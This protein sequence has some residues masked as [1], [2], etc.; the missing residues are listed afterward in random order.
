MGFVLVLPYRYLLGKGDK[1]QRKH[2]SFVDFF[3]L[4]ELAAEHVGLDIIS[5]KEFLETIAMTGQLRDKVDGQVS[6]PPHNRTDW[7][8]IDATDY[9]LLRNWLRNVTHTPLW[10]PGQCLPAFPQSGN[11]RDVELL[12][13]MVTEINEEHQR[14]KHAPLLKF[15]GHPVDVTASARDRLEENL[16]GRHQLCVYDESLQA[17]HIL[18]FQCNHKL[19]MRLL[20]HFYAFLFFE[21]RVW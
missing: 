15:E 16:A 19:H 12:Q 10:N 2:F 13:Q 20:V 14:N 21:V 1:G 6:F 17:E 9:D 5:M 7:D 8:G 4:E 3:P 18:H 11:H